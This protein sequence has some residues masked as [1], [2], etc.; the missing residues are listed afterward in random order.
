MKN[1]IITLVIIL[2][3]A[4]SSTGGFYLWSMHQYKSCYFELTK[5]IESIETETFGLG[6]FMKMLDAGNTDD[7]NHLLALKKQR[8]DCQ[9]YYWQH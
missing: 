8:E 5:E 3:L 4:A 6:V 9:Q 2:T 7:L 1:A